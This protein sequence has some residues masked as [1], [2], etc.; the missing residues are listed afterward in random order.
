MFRLHAPS[1]RPSVRP[2][3]RPSLPEPVTSTCNRAYVRGHGS[4][5]G[6]AANGAEAAGRGAVG[7]KAG[8]GNPRGI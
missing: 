8:P 7:R 2:S 3:V 4:V 6:R 5:A 1:L